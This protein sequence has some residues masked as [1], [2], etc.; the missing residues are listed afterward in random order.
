[1]SCQPVVG[2]SD[3][4][5]AV[6]VVVPAPALSTIGARVSRV[7]PR[8][9]AP[10]EIERLANPRNAPRARIG[11]ESAARRSLHPLS[12]PR[13]APRARIGQESAARRSLHPLANCAVLPERALAR[14]AQPGEA[15]TPLSNPRNAPRARI[16][17]ESR[18]GEDGPGRERRIRRLHRVSAATP[19]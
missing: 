12:N 17:Q 8:R 13:N 11:Q 2:G 5:K 14:K 15:S 10:A 9:G 7:R 3:T 6:D 18:P 1:V 16:G 19:G 4:P